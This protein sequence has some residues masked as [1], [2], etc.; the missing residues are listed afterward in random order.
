MCV[1]GAR[2]CSLT[3]NLSRSQ[4]WDLKEKST[5]ISRGNDLLRN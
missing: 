5:T 1:G 2:L 4:I 3:S